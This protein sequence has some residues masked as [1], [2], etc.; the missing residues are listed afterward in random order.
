MPVGQ[1]PYKQS[2]GKTVNTPDML[3]K[4]NGCKDI[5]KFETEFE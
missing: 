5:A 2:T 4:I 1:I 3:I